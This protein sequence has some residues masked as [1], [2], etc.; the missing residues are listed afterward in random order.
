MTS[1]LV[2]RAI[3]GGRTIFGGR[4]I[5]GG[6]TIFVRRV[7]FRFRFSSVRSSVRAKFFG[8]RPVFGRKN[9]KF[10]TN[11][12]PCC[13]YRVKRH[14]LEY[15]LLA[16]SFTMLLMKLIQITGRS[17]CISYD[18]TFTLRLVFTGS[19]INSIDS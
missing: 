4:E 17:M 7:N 1:F 13:S 12:K 9:Q 5:F 10:W 8:A 6:R 3:F 11:K 15:L 14:I 19:K 16:T 18:G 2:G